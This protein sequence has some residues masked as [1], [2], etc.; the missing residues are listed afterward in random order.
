TRYPSLVNGN[1][2]ALGAFAV[3]TP[4]IRSA[5]GADVNMLKAADF[6]VDSYGNGVIV[7]NEFA[8]KNPQIVERFV[9]AAMRAVDYTIKNR[10]EALQISMKVAPS[11]TREA[12]A[13]RIDVILPFFESDATRKNGLG[14]MEDPVW[15]E[16]QDIMVRY[17]GQTRTVELNR[18]YTNKYL[19]QAGR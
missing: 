16:T 5:A 9:Q 18:L 2:D 3:E 10:D 8:A 1:V 15:R 12:A 11:F 13:A 14:W 7:S 19:K 4:N 17:G 6:G